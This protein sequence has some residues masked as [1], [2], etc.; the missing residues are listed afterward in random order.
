M[1]ASLAR[2]LPRRGEGGNSSERDRLVR[3]AEHK[4]LLCFVNRA[5]GWLAGQAGSGGD[6]LPGVLRSGCRQWG[7]TKHNTLLCLVGLSKAEPQ[8][9]NDEGV[10]TVGAAVPS[11]HHAERSDSSS[12]WS[13][14]FPCLPQLDTRQRASAASVLLPVS[15]GFRLRNGTQQSSRPAERFAGGCAAE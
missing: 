14:S 9:R 11:C 4:T 10:S 15:A 7:G 3:P 6:P 1:P 13:R 5:A 2:A 12:A 8:A